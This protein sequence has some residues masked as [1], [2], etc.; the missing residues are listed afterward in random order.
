ML[1]LELFIKRVSGPELRS[2]EVF[3]FVSSLRLEQRGENTD[4]FIPSHRTE[5]S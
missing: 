5:P 4:L 3:V 1:T 2:P